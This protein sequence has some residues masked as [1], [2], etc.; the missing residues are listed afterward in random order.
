M[1]KPGTMNKG[2]KIDILKKVHL[3]HTKRKIYCSGTGKKIIAYIL[4]FVRNYTITIFSILKTKQESN[5]ADSIHLYCTSQ[6]L[7]NTPTASTSDA[8]IYV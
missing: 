2:T 1:T 4:N 6:F 5:C 3:Y 8:F 7:H